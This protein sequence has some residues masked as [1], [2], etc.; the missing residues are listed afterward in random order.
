LGQLLV[1]ARHTDNSPSSCYESELIPGLINW[2]TQA[3]A[4][5]SSAD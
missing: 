1:V 5:L 3:Q 4:P 2:C